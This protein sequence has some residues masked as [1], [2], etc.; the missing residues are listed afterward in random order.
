MAFVSS[1]AQENKL[2]KF[3]KYETIHAKARV[4]WATSKYYFFLKIFALN[5]MTSQMEKN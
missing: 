1:F 4:A 3:C 5:L 2:H